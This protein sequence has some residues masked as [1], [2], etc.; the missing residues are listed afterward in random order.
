MSSNVTESKRLPGLDLLKAIL[1]LMI[2]ARHTGLISF[3][4]TPGTELSGSVAALL[5]ALYLS[6][7]NLAVPCFMLISLWLYAE[8]RKVRKDYYKKRII[9]LFEIVS[10]WWVIYASATLF[11]PGYP[12]FS[13]TWLGIALLPF[14]DGALYFIASLIIQITAIELIVKLIERVN[15]RHEKLILIVFLTVGFIAAYLGI[16]Y[17]IPLPGI[18]GRFAGLGPLIFCAYGPAALVLSRFS[19]GGG[20]HGSHLGNRWSHCRFLALRSWA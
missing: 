7:Q 2:V 17:I 9:R 16:K 8:K 15:N 1:M 20:A 19:K 3:W 10:F 18:A 13:K 14:I 11:L 12:G 4:P 6:F 5:Q